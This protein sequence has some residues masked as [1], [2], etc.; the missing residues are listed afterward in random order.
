MAKRKLPKT[1]FKLSDLEFEKKKEYFKSKYCKNRP[2]Y[3]P[4]V[5]NFDNCLV[6]VMSKSNHWMSKPIFEYS[7]KTKCMKYF[8]FARTKVVVYWERGS[9]YVTMNFPRNIVNSYKLTLFCELLELDSS[10]KRYMRKRMID[11]NNRNIEELYEISHLFKRYGDSGT[12]AYFG[13]WLYNNK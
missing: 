1:V 6:Q 5:E 2:L 9:R 11:P 4:N 7:T 8:I 3:V 13:N 12:K 10:L